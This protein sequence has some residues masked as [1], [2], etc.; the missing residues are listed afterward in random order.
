MI[1]C[2][3][4]AQHSG[5]K[6][7]VPRGSAAECAADGWRMHVVR[8]GQS[9]N[10][11]AMGVVASHSPDRSSGLSVEQV[12][13]TSF[14]NALSQGLPEC[15]WATGTAEVSDNGANIAWLIC[16][17]LAMAV[18]DGSYKDGFRT[19]A[20]TI[21]GEVLAKRLVATNVMPGQKEDIDSYRSKLR[22]LYRVIVMVK[23]VV[24]CYDI[25]EGQIKVGSD[26]LVGLQRVFMDWS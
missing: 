7:Y 20:F 24:W 11:L 3:G 17:G 22:G 10:F 5:Y 26:C 15:N 2:W 12:T 16:H 8:R 4:R 21:L 18:S 19:A 6:R 14:S 9:G 1:P 13:G 23:Q 25:T